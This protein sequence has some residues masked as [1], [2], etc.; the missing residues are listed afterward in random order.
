MGVLND[1]AYRLRK[2]P[3]LKQKLKDMYQYVGNFLSDKK[4]VPDA[5]E[6]VSSNEKEH[7]FGYYDKKPWNKQED[8]MIYLEVENCYKEVAPL[9]PAKI[10]LKDLKTQEET[11]LETSKT[12]NIQQGNMLQWLGPEFNQ[13]II[14]NDFI[15]G[16]LKSVVLDIET[17]EKKY[18]DLPIY[19]IDK[20]GEF[21]LSLDFF[22][23]HRLRPGYGYSNLEDRTKE[24]KCPDE[25]CIWKLNVKENQVEGILKYTDLYNFEHKKTMEGAEHKVN[26]IMINP[27]GNRFMF[28][29]RWLLDGVKYTRLLTCDMDGKNLYNLLDEDMVSHCT[30]KDDTHI[31]G[32]AHK[33]ET[34]NHYYLLTDQEK[35]A[36]KIEDRLLNVDG[37]PSYA[38]DGS[39]FITD[40]YPD[41][42]RKQKIFLYDL[43]KKVSQEIV[44][45]YAP[46][47]YLNDLR[48]D[49]HPRINYVGNQICFDSCKDGKRQVYVINIERGEG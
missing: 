35:Q 41:F 8:K 11:V 30:W 47:R 45:V 36:E 34:G 15:D 21:A 13:K 49:L 12:W 22:R 29:H 40:T 1:V 38:E 37:H 4:S 19:D 31:L 27:S 3:K 7:L 39:F 5:I 16:K 42:K 6:Q 46:I 33:N 20:K 9:E 32:W 26:H 2:N 48:C 18:F 23:L 25:Y 44:S 10:I 17:K 43:E 14:Y 24:D 28:L